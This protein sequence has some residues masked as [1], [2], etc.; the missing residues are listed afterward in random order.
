[1]NAELAGPLGWD[2]VM[3]RISRF[4]VPRVADWY[5]LV[6]NGVSA[7]ATIGSF[8]HADVER[9]RRLAAMVGQSRDACWPQGTLLGDAATLSRTAFL[10]VVDGVTPAVLEHLCGWT[11]QDMRALGTGSA[12]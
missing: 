9:Q 10:P 8:G 7:G 6:I 12:V 3:R 2:D 11:C 5:L 4:M 1:M